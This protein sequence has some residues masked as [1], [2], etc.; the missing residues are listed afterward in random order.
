MEKITPVAI[1]DEMKRSYIDYAMSVIVSRALPDIRDGLKPVHRRILFAMSGL[2][3]TPDKHFKKSATVVGETLGKYHPHGDLALYD[4]V[5]RMV[6]D[7]SLRYPLIDGQGN[8]GSI[9][10]DAAAAYR[11]TEVRLSKLALYLLQNIEKNTVDFVPNFDGRLKEPVTL[12]SSFP[13]LVVNGASGI[14]VG[15]ATNIPPHNMGEVIDSLIAIIDNPDTDPL[16]HIKGP[17]FPTGGVIVGKRGI[18]DY[19]STGKGRVVVKAKVNIEKSK[20]IKKICITEIPYQV[21]KSNLIERIAEVIK[22]KKM[23]QV[24]ALRD[25]SDKQGMRIVIELRKN[26]N[27]RLI[28][29]NLY[30]HTPMRSTFGVNLLSLK[31]GVPV[32]LSLKELLVSFLEYRYE[33]VERRTKY[34]LEKAEKRAHILE[35]LKIAIDNI[36]EVVEIIKKSKSTKEAKEKLMTRFSLTEVQSQAILDMKLSRLVG[37]E[38]ERLEKEYMEIIKEIEKLRHILSSRRGVYRVIA[39]ELNEIRKKFAD[40]RR[41]EIIEEEEVELSDTDLIPDTEVMVMLTKRGYIKRSRSDIYRIQARGGTGKAGIK[42]TPDDVVSQVLVTTNH[43]RLILFTENGKAFNIS[44]YE[45]PESSRTSRGRSINNL[46]GLSEDDRVISTVPLDNKIKAVLIVTKLG[47]IK[48]IAIEKL[49]KIRRNGVIVIKLR[50]GDVT[51]G[52]EGV[53]KGKEV[54]LA[55]RNGK[56]A[57]IDEADVRLMGRTA[58]G[59]IGMRLKRGD[60]I[61]ALVSPGK[62]RHLFIVTEDGYGKRVKVDKIRKTKRRSKGVILVKGKL[63]DVV[64]VDDEAE[65]IC[66]TKNGKVIKIRLKR[67]R[68][69]GRAAKGVRIIS[70]KNGDRV[71]AV[72]RF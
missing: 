41:S 68:I 43:T 45:I 28:L 44:A 63:A 61:V 65:V 35:G 33:V 2:G 47:I 56:S 37:L 46:L 23:E 70:L 55:T 26:A 39:K 7:F 72:D 40:N 38:R 59:V 36:D 30:K 34:E 62:K 67:V 27:E 32:T 53:S 31:A 4:A 66:V 54:V 16:K 49:K 12:P 18:L 11:Y 71:V 1:E 8:F 48:K 25:E 3:L 22:N 29:N 52:V 14:A 58:Q 17:D 19:V 42:L 69:M 64:P 9:D 20:K 5:T 60:F 6:Q 13:N 50:K 51:I 57:R 10:G 21:N 24:T 15:M